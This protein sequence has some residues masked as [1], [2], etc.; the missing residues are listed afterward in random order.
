[1]QVGFQWLDMESIGAIEL[2]D[3]S[4]LSKNTSCQLIE[5]IVLNTNGSLYGWAKCLLTVSGTAITLDYEHFPKINLNRNML[6]GILRFEYDR[7]SIPPISNVAWKKKDEPS[8]YD[9]N[10]K[11]VRKRT[12]YKTLEDSQADFEN[13]VASALLSSEE[14]L[15]IRLLNINN[16]PLKRTVTTSIFIRNPDVVALALIRAEGKCGKCGENAPF[17]KKKDQEPYLE[18]HHKK[19]LAQGGLDIVENTIVLCPNCHRECHY[20]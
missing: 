9:V 15:N 16:H 4:F 6:L 1:M 2:F 11:F 3:E 12:S 14:E 17:L 8:F 19:P 13:E 20:G 5:H 18:V 7:N 10:F